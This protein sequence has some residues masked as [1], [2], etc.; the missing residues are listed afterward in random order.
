VQEANLATSR[1]EARSFPGG[2]VG[3]LR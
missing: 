3:S 1:A 2:G